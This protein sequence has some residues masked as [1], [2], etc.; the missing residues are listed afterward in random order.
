VFWTALDRYQSGQNK[1]LD[2]R[3]PQGWMAKLINA[4][5]KHLRHEPQ[6]LRV[7]KGRRGVDGGTGRREMT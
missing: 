7:A 1:P 3:R 5:G 4:A 2:L 6:K